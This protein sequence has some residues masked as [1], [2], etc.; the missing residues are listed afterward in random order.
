LEDLTNVQFPIH[1][2]GI[3]HGSDPRSLLLKQVRDIRALLREFRVSSL[4][5]AF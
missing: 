1:N 5:L 3:E 2:L 4:D